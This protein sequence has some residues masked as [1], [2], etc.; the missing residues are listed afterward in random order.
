MIVN[1]AGDTIARLAG[2]NASGVNRVEWNLR[3]TGDQAVTLAGAGRGG[4]GGG[5]PVP[6][7]G[8][9]AGQS[10]TPAG[11]PSGF[12]PRPAES[13]AAPDSSGSPTFQAR[14]AGAGGG[15]GGRGA[16]GAVDSGAA[17]PRQSRRVTIAS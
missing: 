16:G 14:D 4:R 1:V 8:S 3:A 17:T 12:N 6:A 15:R 10:V 2:T 11:F 9:G 7:A 5:G 13:N